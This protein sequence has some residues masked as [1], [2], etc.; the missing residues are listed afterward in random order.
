M[1]ELEQRTG[2]HREVIRLMIREGLLPEP[3][4]PA[5]NLAVYNE[6]H[7]TS[8]GAVREL[9]QRSH[10]TLKEIRAAIDRRGLANGGPPSALPHLQALL[11][12]RFG[13]E[14]GGSVSV[15]ELATRYP[16][17]ERDAA[18]FAAMG[19]L[20]LLDGESGP[21]LTLSDSRLVEIW[22]E[23]RDAGFVEE[24]GFP[25]ENIA[26]YLD[27]ARKVAASEA[28]V[29]FENGSTA[30]SDERAA[31]MLHL[32][33]PLML[34][35]FGLLRTKAFLSEVHT[36]SRAGGQRESKPRSL[37]TGSDGDGVGKSLTAARR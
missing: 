5:R 24:A 3:Q 18:A 23:I 37:K 33:L 27:A 13:L 16:Q 14:D 31:F 9:Q 22:G 20:T 12:S 11:A 1:R 6:D 8:I 35:F 25:P 2:V 28:R 34:E 29:F 4:R 7:V 10:L 32:A 19:M 17:A 30:F 15:R 21:A 26:F 36:R